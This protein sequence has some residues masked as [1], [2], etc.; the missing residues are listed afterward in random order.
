MFKK[1][2]EKAKDLSDKAEISSRLESAL[3]MTKQVAADQF[4]ASKIKASDLIEGNWE[5]MEEALSKLWPNIESELVKRFVDVAEEKL[6]DAGSIE[7]VFTKSYELLPAP[8]RLVL[9][10]KYYI[11]YCMSHREPL[12]EKVRVFKADNYADSVAKQQLLK[13]FSAA[14]AEAEAS[15]FVLQAASQDLVAHQD[16]ATQQT[17]S[18]TKICPMCAEDI[19]LAA[20]VCRYCGHKYATPES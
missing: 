7:A 5:R 16:S 4:S 17:L 8:V 19:K 13:Q 1:F 20:I 18:V 9:S 11:D 10:R 2:M 15:A 6:A 14:N 3:E 12:L